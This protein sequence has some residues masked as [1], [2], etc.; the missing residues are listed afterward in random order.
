[1][2]AVVLLGV[3]LVVAVVVVVVVL[4][5]FVSS[6]A[7]LKLSGGVAVVVSGEWDDLEGRGQT[8]YT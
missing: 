1:M 3:A 6:S 7:S 5:V 8:S 4:G 2:V